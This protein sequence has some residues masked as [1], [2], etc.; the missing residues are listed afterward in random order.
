MSRSTE[1][2]DGTYELRHEQTTYQ[3][4]QTKGQTTTDKQNLQIKNRNR[5]RPPQQTCISEAANATAF[6]RNPTE[7]AAPAAHRHQ[8]MDRTASAVGDPR[9][10]PSSRKPWPK[11]ITLDGSADGAP[12]DDGGLS[13]FPKEASTAPLLMKARVR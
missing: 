1:I 11:F 8:H 6:G 2:Q 10:P 12:G 5:H 9:S 7:I 3:T 4:R 13:P